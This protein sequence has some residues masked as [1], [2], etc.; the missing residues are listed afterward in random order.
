MT[1]NHLYSRKASRAF[2]ALACTAVFWVGSVYAAPGAHG[3]NGEHLDGPAANQTQRGGATVPRMEAASEAFELVAKMYGEELSIQIDRFETNEPVLDAKVEVESNGIKAPGKF[4]AD[5]GD[6]AFTDERLL[7]ALSQ[8]GKH[9]L[10]FT[11]FAGNES[12]LLEG[13]I[14]VSSG[15]QDDHDDGHG[16]DHVPAWVKAGGVLAAVLVLAG[17]LRI[18]RSNN[19]KTSRT[20]GTAGS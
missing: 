10:V 13:T 19:S 2:A 9:P 1:L 14:D 12:D 11:V 5:H 15:R 7:K 3:P 17:I 4:H 16:H 18:R 20:S 6:Y 8:P